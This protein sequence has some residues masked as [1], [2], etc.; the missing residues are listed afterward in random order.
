MTQI[1]TNISDVIGRKTDNSRVE[2]FVSL[3]KL[4]YINDACAVVYELPNSKTI[5]I[6]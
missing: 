6:G 4:R 2:L 1:H 3:K 5:E